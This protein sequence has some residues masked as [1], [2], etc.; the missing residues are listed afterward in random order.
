MFCEDD[1]CRKKRQIIDVLQTESLLLYCQKRLEQTTSK[2]KKHHWLKKCQCR[3]NR[4]SI[5]SVVFACCCLSMVSVPCVRQS[6]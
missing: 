3:L 2:M 1:R 6:T 5:Y 4:T